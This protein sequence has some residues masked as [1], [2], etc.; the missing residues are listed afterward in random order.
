M[1]KGEKFRLKASEIIYKFAREN[2]KSTY[3]E[4]D[5]SSGSY[6]TATGKVTESTETHS[7][8]MAFDEIAMS[9]VSTGNTPVIDPQFLKDNMLALIAG[10]DLGF[11]PQEDAYIT[12]VG[13]TGRHRIIMVVSDMYQ[14]LYQCYITR[15]IV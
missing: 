15:S 10:D 8:Y 14:A 7:C 6:D 13:E 12:P 2:G 9:I 11:K 1:T 4:I 5:A 3:H